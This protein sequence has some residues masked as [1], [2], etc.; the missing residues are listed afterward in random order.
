M[1]K[2]CCRPVNLKSYAKISKPGDFRFFLNK[3]G[4]FGQKQVDRDEIINLL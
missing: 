1:D 2:L 3:T 4:G